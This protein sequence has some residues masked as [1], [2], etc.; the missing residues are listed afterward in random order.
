AVTYFLIVWF[1][2]NLHGDFYYFVLILYVSLIATNSFV[3][4][5]S[6]IVPNYIMGYAAVIAF[7]AIFFLFC[8]FFIPHDSIPPYWKWMHYISTIKY[9][10]EG[11]MMNQFSRNGI[12]Y[13]YA[14]NSTTEC[15]LHRLE[16]LKSLAISTDKMA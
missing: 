13:V 4:F 10:Y 3:V 2:L 15:A 14:P 12:C 1:A 9:S 7:T 8:G 5:V 16:T 11:M 6:A